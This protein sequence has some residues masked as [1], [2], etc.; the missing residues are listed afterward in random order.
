MT[1]LKKLPE[2]R[3]AAEYGYFE[4][5]FADGDY[6]SR[7]LRAREYKD[8]RG[9]IRCAATELIR[10]F[11]EPVTHAKGVEAAKLT[12]MFSSLMTLV[13]SFAYFITIAGDFAFALALI[14]VVGGLAIVVSRANVIASVGREFK[15][16]NKNNVYKITSLIVAYAILPVAVIIYIIASA[17]LMP[18]YDYIQ[19][20]LISVVWIL[21]C[22][23][24]LPRFIAKRTDEAQAM[25]GRMLGFKNFLRLA[26][27]SEM[28][29]LLEENP[30]YYL[31]IL[32]YCM[33]MG[34]SKR[35][36]K[37][38]EFLAAPEWADGFSAK[39]FASSLFCSVKRSAITRKRR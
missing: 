19:L 6:S 3:L 36:D 8:R 16:I 28:E 20:T 24:V 26:K 21:V 15:I 22:L 7:R 39:R 17:H 33:I 4:A 32:P 2:G 11:G 38:T 14:L 9:D 35:L 30:D 18:V 10:E 13:I 23:Y 29:K 27:V 31:D 5:L 25:Y 37:K 12:V 34:L 1:R